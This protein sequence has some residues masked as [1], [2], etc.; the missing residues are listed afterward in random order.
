[1]RKADDL[2]VAEVD[3]DHPLGQSRLERL[4]DHQPAA[5]EV[6]LTA[7][8]ELVERDAPRYGSPRGM[9][10]P[11]RSPG[12]ARPSRRRYRP[13]PGAASARA[14]RAGR[15]GPGAPLGAVR[16]RRRGA[17]GAP[18]HPGGVDEHLLGSHL[19]ITSGWADTQT[20]AS[21]TSRSSGSSRERS[22]PCSI[23][24]TQ[25][26]TPSSRAAARAPRRRDA[27]GVDDRLGLRHRAPRTRRT[28]LAA[29]R[30]RTFPAATTG[31][32]S[33]RQ[34]SPTR[35][36]ASAIHG[37]GNEASAA[38]RT[39]RWTPWRS[40]SSRRRIVGAFRPPKDGSRLATTSAA[41]WARTMRPSRAQSARCASAYRTPSSSPRPNAVGD[42]W[43]NASPTGV[44]TGARRAQVR[45]DELHGHRALADG[46]RAALG[47]AGAHVA[48]RE[49][50]GHARLEQVVGARVGAGEDE[51]VARRARR[52]RRATRCTATRRGR[53]T[54]T[55]TAG[56]R[57]SSA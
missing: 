43:S 28:S 45:V 33:E 54:G 34:R 3:A 25:T 1:M 18:A 35:T 29:D 51:A 48:R 23:G 55:R 13:C 17:S 21:P 6:R 32:H 15:G 20:P 52:H 14:A 19:A 49:D 10:H 44:A 36:S 40:R 57:R 30:S 47:R 41:L 31:S 2:V 7:L 38:S 12:A 4:L 11:S 37:S 26:R 27:V 39:T 24:L 50:A 8:D 56:A 9:L 5:R 53:G 46:R 22:W 16:G 42:D